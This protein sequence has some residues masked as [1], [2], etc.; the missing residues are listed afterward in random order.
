MLLPEFGLGAL[1]A[2]LWPLI[3]TMVRIGAALLAAPLFG[4]MSVPVQL[5][6]VLAGAIAVFVL[7]W[8]PVAVPSDMG[9]A[10]GLVAIA[11]EA[12][13]GLALGFTLQLAFAAPLIGAEIISG[14]M[15]MAIATAIDPNSG[16]QS[17]AL[18]QYF[19]IV[20]TLV[21]LAVGGHLL[22]LELVIESY[23]ALPPGSGAIGPA[24]GARIAGFAV[25]MFA[26]GLAIALPVT[27]VLLLVQLTTG[28]ISRSAPALNLFALGLPAG[29][30]AGLAALIASAPLLTDRFVQLSRAAIDEAA[31]LVPA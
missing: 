14:T 26:T 5:R 25:R 18:G 15:G 20:L 17:G 24:D 12:L 27:L 3:F 21:F 6:I 19:G 11:G 7:A 30:L 1:E 10:G 29:I 31:S 22:W 28:V 16:A 4:A 23:T 9:V 8:T 13:I 2:Q